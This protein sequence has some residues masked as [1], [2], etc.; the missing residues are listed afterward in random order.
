LKKRSDRDPPTVPSETAIAIVA[1]G[2][3][4]RE[5]FSLPTNSI[6]VIDSFVTPK[7]CKSI[8]KEMKA[9][10]W[11]PSRILRFRLGKQQ[12]AIDVHFRSS[13][14]TYEEWF[15]PNLLKLIRAIEVQLSEIFRTNPDC[16]ERWQAV[17]YEHG[18]EFDY[19]LDCGSWNRTPEGERTKTFLIF[20]QSPRRGG[21]THFRALNQLIKPR[22]GRL[23]A[24]NNLL[25]NGN[26]N[27][28]MIHG[29]LPVREG[30]KIVLVTWE[31][32]RPISKDS[33]MP[34]Q[35]SK[36]QAGRENRQSCHQ[37]V[38]KYDLKK[39]PYVLIEI[40]RRYHF[41]VPDGGLPPGG[42]PP[43]PE[44]HGQIWVDNEMLLREITQLRQEISA[45]KDKIG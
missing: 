25:D 34:K 23:L 42:T 19:H 43:P 33:L 30:V 26:C 35:R 8:V 45:L 28:A 22:P 24:W 32:E 13:L 37:Q 29:G 4:Q 40:L 12:S 44:P 5:K 11:C 14:S 7:E 38:R 15:G 41:D 9:C 18:A 27:H 39:N 2:R 36:G 10:C 6:A 16:L 21:E 1:S 17:K 20:L 31:R 3:N